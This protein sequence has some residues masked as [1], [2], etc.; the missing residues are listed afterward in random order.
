MNNAFPAETQR[1]AF[2]IL[3]NP[4]LKPICMKNLLPLSA[5]SLLLVAAG[6]AYD[7]G[8]VTYNGTTYGRPAVATSSSYST[9]SR[10]HSSPYVTNGTYTYTPTLPGDSY[11][12]AP[13]HSSTTT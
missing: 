8:P 13:S 3:T 7:D 6:C 9:S 11:L 4:K 5:A 10:Y 12:Q 2:F 1:K